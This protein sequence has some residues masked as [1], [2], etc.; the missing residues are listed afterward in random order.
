MAAGMARSLRPQP[1]PGYFSAQV[2]EA[3]R[4][5]LRRMG[6]AGPPVQV[7]SGGFERCRP[8]Y[9][10]DR[11]GFPHPILEFVVAGAGRLELGA[12]TH[13]LVPGTVFVYGR[14]VA[15]RMSCDPARPLR[16]YF[17][18]M[19]GPGLRAHL[20][21]HGLRPGRVLRVGQLDRIQHLLD[22]LIAFA[23]GDRADRET[24]CASLCHYLITKLSDLAAPE[25]AA[26][27]RACATYERCRTY[28]ESHFLTA[29]GTRGVARA[30]HVDE[31]YLCRLFQRFGRE[32]PFH[33]LQHLR[34][35]HAAAVLLGGERMVKDLAAELGFGDPAN[36]TRAFRRWF[37][38][39][40]QEF[41]R[42][43]LSEGPARRAGPAP[44]M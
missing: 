15:H 33:Y 22:D 29:G 19:A 18:A 41:R 32:R 16:K 21:R 38:V 31:S 6:P 2:V 24:C 25:G 5:H 27:A 4:F 9:R 37:G 13:L 7:V 11:T 40:P 26:E 14:G 23:L 12:A 36:F 1:E 17:V 42:G 43:R 20:A 8:D 10:I 34:L 28:M 3:R 30:C 44:A 35:N 39:S